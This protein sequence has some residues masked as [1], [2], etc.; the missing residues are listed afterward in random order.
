MVDV[1]SISVRRMKTSFKNYTMETL[2]SGV[3]FKG[4]KL[5]MM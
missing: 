4:K 1:L 3:Q 2:N 5:V